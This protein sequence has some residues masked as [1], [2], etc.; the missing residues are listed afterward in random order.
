MLGTCQETPGLAWPQVKALTRQ[1]IRK[2]CSWTPEK[3]SVE[4]KGRCSNPPDATHVTSPAMGA[5]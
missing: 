2:S 4:G 3:I 5:L 1:S